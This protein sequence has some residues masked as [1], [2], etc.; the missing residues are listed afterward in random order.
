LT[1]LI[2]TIY[3]ALDTVSRE[4]IGFIPNVSRDS[5]AEQAALNQ[6]VRAHIVPETTL[7]DIT[8]GAQPAD[9]GDQV[10]SYVDLT[11]TNSKAAPIRWTGE[12]QLSVKDKLNPILI[13]QFAQAF[14]T[15]ANA[16]ES[17]LASLYVKASRAYG[18]AGT[19]PFGTAAD[20]TDFAEMNRILDENGAPATG[21]VMILGHAARAKLEGKHSELFK[22]TRRAQASATTSTTVPAKRSVRPPFRWTVAR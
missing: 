21:R 20:L 8:P 1:G 15:L 22:V 19:T 14:R 4:L 18:T 11:I 12:E 10:L 6:T 17:D 13:D 5:K 7:E 9:S 2:P 3:T 16:V